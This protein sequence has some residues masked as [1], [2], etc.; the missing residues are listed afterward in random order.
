MIWKAFLTLFLGLHPAF[1][2]E[3]SLML[4]IKSKVALEDYNKTLSG[5]KI[6]AETL[7]T[8]PESVTF[9]IRF[10]YK[11]LGGYEGKL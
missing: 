10:N 1:S 7:E 9:C 11:L 3:D 5:A 4:V 8:P 2:F 6:V